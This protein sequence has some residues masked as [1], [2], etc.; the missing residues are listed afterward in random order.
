[1]SADA[2]ARPTKL[3]VWETLWAAVYETRGSFDIYMRLVW[4]PFLASL[5][6]NAVLAVTSPNTLVETPDEAGPWSARDLI[7]MFIWTGVS[8]TLLPALTGWHR[9]L[10]LGPSHPSGRRRYSIAGK[11]SDYFKAVLKVGGVFVSALIVIGLL[12]EVDQFDASL[13]ENRLWFLP[14]YAVASFAIARFL[15]LFPAAAVGQPLAMR[16][17]RSLPLGNTVHLWF[18]VLAPEAVSFMA[19]MVLRV[20]LLGLE[21][22]EVSR[23]SAVAYAITRTVIGFLFLSVSVA[24]L[25]ISYRQIVAAAPTEAAR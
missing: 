1:V 19:D 2:I 8:V 17:A 7:D 15:F 12:L 16:D 4:I 21:A 13:I 9:H 22:T 11:E 6:Y 24:A 20:M 23:A 3:P 14:V 10:I 25:S 18:V 5:A